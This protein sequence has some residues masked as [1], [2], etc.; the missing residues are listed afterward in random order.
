MCTRHTRA[1]WI[2]YRHVFPR[3][4]VVDKSDLDGG[5]PMTSHHAAPRLDRIPSYTY[6]LKRSCWQDRIFCMVWV[7]QRMLV[8]Q[9]EGWYRQ[10]SRTQDAGVAWA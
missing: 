1:L 10:G 7:D 8:I 2:T 5:G 9:R 6:V 3:L 4:L